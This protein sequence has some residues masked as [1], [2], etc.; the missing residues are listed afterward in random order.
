MS[1]SNAVPTREHGPNMHSPADQ[2]KP[3][4][5]SRG[6]PGTHINPESIDNP[7][8]EGHIPTLDGEAEQRLIALL[9]GASHRL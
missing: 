4:E 6:L 7:L 8:E 9:D 2:T 5:E 1:L 3:Y